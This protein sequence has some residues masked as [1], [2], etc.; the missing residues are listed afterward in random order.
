M[1]KTWTKKKL[2]TLANKVNE[3]VQPK[4]ENRRINREGFRQ[5][6]LRLLDE[7][8]PVK[9]NQD[10][11]CDLNTDADE[12]ELCGTTACL[13][14]H[15][16]ILAGFTVPEILA[17]G[18]DGDML[19]GEKFDFLNSILEGQIATIGAKYLGLT[20]GATRLFYPSGSGF[21]EPYGRDFYHAK[22]WTEKRRIAAEMCLDIA[23]GK[24]D[25]Y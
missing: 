21:P 25:V 13:A 16:A 5:L 20:N 11:W 23:D 9:Y 7:S 15:A 19:G 18:D 14:G 10:V 12:R 4:D 22:N 8:N 3:F 1:T 2:I 6:G 17:I 24:V